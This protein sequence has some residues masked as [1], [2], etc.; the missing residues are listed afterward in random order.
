MCLLQAC[1]LHLLSASR[2]MGGE[3]SGLVTTRALIRCTAE[4]SLAFFGVD[5][6]FWEPATRV[7]TAPLRCCALVRLARV[8]LPESHPSAEARGRAPD[9]LSGFKQA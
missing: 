9:L 4:H 6:T 2:E 7:H 3:P 1:L 5:R 8:R